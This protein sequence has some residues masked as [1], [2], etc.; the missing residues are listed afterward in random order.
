MQEKLLVIRKRE[1]IT[2]RK[3][4]KMLGITEQCYHQ[5]EYGIRPFNINE[6]FK[7]SNF[8]NMKIEDIFLPYEVQKGLKN[9]G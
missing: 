3:M 2:G 5:K 8:F 9:R 6:M 4:A 1:K 7:I